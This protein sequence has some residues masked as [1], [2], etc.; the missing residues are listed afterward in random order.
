MAT[1]FSLCRH[2]TNLETELAGL[3][4]RRPQT[5]GFG[6]VAPY[7]RH[8]GGV[9]YLT[10]GD[11]AQQ[12]SLGG[13]LTSPSDYSAV[14]KSATGSPIGTP[15]WDQ[16]SLTHLVDKRQPAG[17]PAAGSQGPEGYFNSK[18]R[19]TPARQETWGAGALRSRAGSKENSPGDRRHSLLSASRLG[20]DAPSS[21]PLL[22]KA[23]PEPDEVAAQTPKEPTVK[24]AHEAGTDALDEAA[25]MN[26][27]DR[28]GEP[29]K[30]RHGHTVLH[31]HGED[32]ASTFQSLP[33][34]SSLLS[35]PPP[36]S[37]APSRS[38]ALATLGADMPPSV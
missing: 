20:Q 16:G 10:S 11:V 37:S 17:S 9:S 13:S 3:Q 18:Q 23:H 8:F 36:T 14:S 21:E 33:P 7:P 32:F 1:S 30:A 27:S 25:A 38:S 31:S 29:A 24:N 35:R 19:P 34:S 26:P 12:H 5:A 28:L 22:D 15:S 2:Y 4:R 6:A